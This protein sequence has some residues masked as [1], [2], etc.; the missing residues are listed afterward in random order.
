MSIKA[1]TQVI[2]VP[3]TPV[4][5]GWQLI[6]WPALLPNN[7][8]NLSRQFML[9]RAQKTCAV[10]EAISAIWLWDEQTVAQLNAKRAASEALLDQTTAAELAA[11]GARGTLDAGLD[12]LYDYAVQG[13]ALARVK[14]SGDAGKKHILTSLSSVGNSRPAKRATVKQWA[15]AWNQLDPLWVLNLMGGTLTLVQYQNL[16]K[17]LEGDD[18]AVPPVAGTYDAM[19]LAVQVARSKAESLNAAL[20][21]TEAV[22]ERW[23]AT[24][25]A[26]CP[27]GSPAG[28]Q[29]RG[30][31]PTTYN[32]NEEPLPIPPT[33]SGVAAQ[34]VVGSGT[35][36]AL[37]FPATYAAEYVWTYTYTLP[38]DPP[39]VLQLTTTETTVSFTDPTTDASGTLTV[40]AQ[41]A[42]GISAA[43]APVNVEQ[44]P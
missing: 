12:E 3:D 22:M 26:V 24:A 9:N 15:M 43:S 33:P 21:A 11:E 6:H 17:T 44:V 36:N 38:G 40:A 28:D 4:C 41:N 27:A 34:T 30:Q 19:E 29:I 20:T 35:I 13:M 5:G 31:I 42:T 14:Y 7:M 10:A 2:P 32:P 18:T 39:A 25:V 37:C 1:H 8:P 23:Y 16:R